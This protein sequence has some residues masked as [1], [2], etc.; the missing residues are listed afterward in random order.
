MLFTSCWRA[1]VAKRVPMWMVGGLVL[2][3]MEPEYLREKEDLEM[4]RDPEEVETR[5]LY[6]YAE[7]AGT[8]V[9]EIGCGEGRLIWRYAMTV[10]QVV[11]LD[12][13]AVRLAGA[14]RDCPP[15]LRARMR[16]VRGQAEALPFAAARF[17]RVILGWS[18]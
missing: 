17:E 10:G 13:D 15:T 12:P 2:V 18:L 8:R 4:E 7:L 14:V 3:G 11:G 1:R 5:T 16:L 6:K 9:L